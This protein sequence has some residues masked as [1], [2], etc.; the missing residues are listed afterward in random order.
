MSLPRLLLVSSLFFAAA[1]DTSEVALSA[2][3]Y[4]RGLKSSRL[5]AGW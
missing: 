5:I 2:P 1:V 4:L 3:R